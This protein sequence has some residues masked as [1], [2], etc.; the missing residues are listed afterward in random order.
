MT[1]GKIYHTAQTHYLAA[2]LEYS[3]FETSGARIKIGDIPKGAQPVRWTATLQSAFAS[4]SAS[5]P[6]FV[7]GTDA[8][9][10]R[11][12]LTTGIG[13]A[14]TGFYSGTTGAGIATV[15]LAVYAQLSQGAMAAMPTTGKVFYALEYI[16][17]NDNKNLNSTFD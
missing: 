16:A 10:A 3:D 12:L 5:L 17:P 14:T 4:S 1:A 2:E 11:F 8:D 15:D 7:V 6:L 13:L 9:T